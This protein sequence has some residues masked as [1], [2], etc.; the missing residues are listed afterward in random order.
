MP[1]IA[2]GSHVT[3]RVGPLFESTN[4]LSTAG[5]G[6]KRKR[7]FRRHFKGIVLGSGRASTQEKRTWKVLWMDCGKCCDHSAR[8]LSVYKRPCMHFD[9]KEYSH[10][11]RDI[12]YFS[13][14]KSLTNYIDEGNYSSN[15][16]INLAQR[17]AQDKDTTQQGQDRSVTTSMLQSPTEPCQHDKGLPVSA[18]AAA[19]SLMHLATGDTAAANNASYTGAPVPPGNGTT[20][21]SRTQTQPT[22]DTTL[23]S[24]EYTS[25]INMTHPSALVVQ[26]DVIRDDTPVEGLRER[27]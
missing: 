17:P 12:D 20:D 18:A 23:D 24:T 11:L 1:P 15:I 4:N 2:I 27:E 3:A 9:I 14:V 5:P 13:D 25:T 22:T 19:H 6:G 16:E 8:V 7:R 21:S 10:N 26:N